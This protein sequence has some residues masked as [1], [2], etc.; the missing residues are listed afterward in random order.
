[1]LKKINYYGSVSCPINNGIQ[2]QLEA[3]KIVFSDED[4]EATLDS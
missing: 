2:K 4:N 3:T 1:M